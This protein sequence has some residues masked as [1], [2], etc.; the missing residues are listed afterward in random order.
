MN[1]D[2]PFITPDELAELIRRVAPAH[3]AEDILRNHRKKRVSGDESDEE[4]DG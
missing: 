3:A 1:L 4:E 2:S